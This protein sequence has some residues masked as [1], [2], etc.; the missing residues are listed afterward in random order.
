MPRLGSRVR[1]PFPAPTIASSSG[2]FQS[3][4]TTFQKHPIGWA[5][6]RG[7]P[8]LGALHWGHRIGDTHLT[9]PRSGHLARDTPMGTPTALDTPM[10]TP[11]ALD[12]PMGTPTALGTSPGTPTPCGDTQ[13][14]DPYRKTWRSVAPTPPANRWLAEQPPLKS[15][16]F[17]ARDR[18]TSPSPSRSANRPPRRLGSGVAPSAASLHSGPPFANLGLRYLARHLRPSRGQHRVAEHRHDRKHAC[19]A[20]SPNPS[21]NGLRPGTDAATP[22]PNA[23][24]TGTVTVDV[25][26]PRL[27]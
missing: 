11:T 23:A 20:I 27:S 3:S 1:T 2:G 18:A 12:T 19:K 17:A 14:T 7:Q 25:V 22:N 13:C 26:T 21:I 6:I 9:A 16:R 5:P 10:G 15:P 4:A 8:L 24:T